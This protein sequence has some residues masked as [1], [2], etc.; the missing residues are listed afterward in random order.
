MMGG[1]LTKTGGAS[2]IQVPYGKTIFSGEGNHLF[3]E[4]RQKDEQVWKKQ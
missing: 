2:K 3:G 1:W 4:R